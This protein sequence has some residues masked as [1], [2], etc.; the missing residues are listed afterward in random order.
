M[1]TFVPQPTHYVVDNRSWVGVKEA[2]F[3]AS[4]GGLRDPWGK[5]WKPVTASSIGDARR[6]GA[7][8]FGIKL[9][10]I[11]DGEQ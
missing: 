9:S 8:M 5:N 6:K 10:H 2:E 1:L 7:E 11:Y 3:F 4:Q